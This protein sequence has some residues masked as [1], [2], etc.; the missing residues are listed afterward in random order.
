M[1]R[2]IATQLFLLLAIG[3][4]AGPVEEAARLQGFR[5]SI[6]RDFGNLALTNEEVLDRISGHVNR[7][8][9]V[10]PEHKNFWSDLIAKKTT[11]Q[12]ASAP[13]DDF[14]AKIMQETEKG[15]LKVVETVQKMK[16]QGADLSAEAKKLYLELA[17]QIDAS[18]RTQFVSQLYADVAYALEN[19]QE[20]VYLKINKSYLQAVVDAFFDSFNELMEQQ[21]LGVVIEE[22]FA[23]SIVGVIDQNSKEMNAMV[24]QVGEVLDLIANGARQLRMEALYMFSYIQ[25]FSLETA[26]FMPKVRLARLHLIMELLVLFGVSRDSLDQVEKFTEA[27]FRH[28]KDILRGKEVADAQFAPLYLAVVNSFL[29][30]L[31]QQVG[32]KTA[33]EVTQRFLGMSQET[34]LGHFQPFLQAH[35]KTHGFPVLK[36]TYAFQND[37]DLIYTA[38]ILTTLSFKDVSAEWWDSLFSLRAVEKVLAVDANTINALGYITI[39]FHS[40]IVPHTDDSAAYLDSFFDAILTFLELYG[41]QIFPEDYFSAFNSFLDLFAPLREHIGQFYFFMKL[42]NI[43]VSPSSTLFPVSFLALPS[44]PVQVL[45][46]KKLSDAPAFRTVSAIAW[47]TYVKLTGLNKKK[48]KEAA[49]HF[50]HFLGKQDFPSQVFPHADFGFDVVAEER[51][52]RPTNK[53]VSVVIEQRADLV[54][55]QTPMQTPH[56]ISVDSGA[57]KVSSPV[58]DIDEDDFP[59]LPKLARTKDQEYYVP[60]DLMAEIKAKEAH[61]DVNE[62]EEAPESPKLTRTKDQE[63]YVSSDLMAEIKA[64]EAEPVVPAIED[65]EDEF[66]ELPKLT[67][68]KEREYFVPADFQDG[69]HDVNEDIDSEDEAPRTPVLRRQ[70][71]QIFS[72]SPMRTPSMED[73]PS[74]PQEDLTIPNEDLEKMVQEQIK[75]AKLREEVAEYVNKLMEDV[76]KSQEDSPKH[77]EPAEVEEEESKPVSED[78]EESL[79]EVHTLSGELSPLEE[80]LLEQPNLEDILKELSEITDEF[81]TVTNFALV[82]LVPKESSCF[83]TLFA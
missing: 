67:R 61:P 31:K 22:E 50:L 41:K 10:A 33:Y 60:S 5:S 49:E 52:L 73:I 77:N 27:L 51:N 38:A 7:V 48:N 69:H 45:E 20:K 21:E 11:Y 75:E 24:V 34:K 81:G 42:Q 2:S 15:L 44:D 35:L 25:I 66:P 4:A 65:D 29:S 54:V 9:G 36:E 17:T 59:E 28:R 58:S 78:K 76:L 12:P 63:Y 6:L 18:C 19:L 83:T 39:Q 32:S 8:L 62:E 43:Y 82:K 37:R 13:Q 74:V 80:K 70:N 55:R 1:V 72:A 40:N 79:T 14:N 30:I 71:A 53:P 46:L 23:D 16:G 68:T 64:K 47:N 3:V 57:E 26:T 56:K